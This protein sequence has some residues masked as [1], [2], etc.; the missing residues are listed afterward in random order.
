MGG[1]GKWD[2]RERKSTIVMKK[3]VRINKIDKVSEKKR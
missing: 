2:G 3:E 1:K